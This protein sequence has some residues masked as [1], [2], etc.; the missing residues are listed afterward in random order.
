M[1][2]LEL[3]WKILPMMFF[4]FLA[5]ELLFAIELLLLQPEMFFLSM[6]LPQ[7]KVFVDPLF[8]IR[9]FLVFRC[10]MLAEVWYIHF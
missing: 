4:F 9:E 5:V 1:E 7:F 3:F 10:F 2:F 6:L 8:E